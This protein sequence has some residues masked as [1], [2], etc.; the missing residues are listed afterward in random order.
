MNGSSVPLSNFDPNSTSDLVNSIYDE[1]PDDSSNDW[2]NSILNNSA[3]NS[4]NSVSSVASNLRRLTWNTR[5][6]ETE[7]A[8]AVESILSGAGEETDIPVDLCE[9]DGLDGTLEDEEEEDEEDEDDEEE[10]DEVNGFSE[11][12]AGQHSDV[13]M[14]C[15]I[16]SI[17]DVPVQQ[18]HNSAYYNNQIS[19]HMND[20]R[21]GLPSHLRHQNRHPGY[22]R[23]YSLGNGVNDPV[24]EEAVKSILSQ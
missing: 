22:Q 14:Q 12:P 7:A 10:E 24:L 17:L 5:Y 21:Y 11:D 18:H 9:I 16:K 8:V 19:S 4:V 2:T 13:Q 15:A 1:I 20:F 23:D 3:V 6:Q